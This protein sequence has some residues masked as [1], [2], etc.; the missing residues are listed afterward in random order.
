VRRNLQVCG[1][2]GIPRGPANFS[3]SNTRF[4][5]K[6]GGGRCIDRLAA[7]KIVRWRGR[8]RTSDGQPVST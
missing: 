5:R 7:V 2:A 3:A 6:R 4:R 8:H 1:R